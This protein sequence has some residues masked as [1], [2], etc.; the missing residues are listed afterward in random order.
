M[1]VGDGFEGATKSQPPRIVI[2]GGRSGC[3][4]EREALIPGSHHVGHMAALSIRDAGVV[5]IVGV[6]RYRCKNGKHEQGHQGR[7]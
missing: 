1:A 4:L 3:I 7:I 6:G 2:H 5:D